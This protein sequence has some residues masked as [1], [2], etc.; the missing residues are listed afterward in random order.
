[1][2]FRPGPRL[3]DAAAL[4]A[5]LLVVVISFRDPIFRGLVAFERDTEV[6]FYPLSAWFSE[7]FK[8]GRFP[9]WTPHVFAGYP[10]LADGENG[11]ANPLNLLFLKFLSAGH[12]LLWQRVSS[13]A[14]A[15]LGM[16]ALCRALGVGSLAA[17]LGAT[18]FSL[19]SFFPSQQHHENVTRT[20]A[21]LPMVLA[22]VEWSFHHKGWRRHAFLTAG[23]L[24]LGM[25]TVGLHPQI[26]AMSLLGFSSFVTYR[27]LTL[28]APG[29]SWGPLGLLWR[30]ALVAWVGLYAGLL[31][32]ALGALQLVPLAEL[33]TSTYRGSQPDYF[34]ATSYALP[35]PNLIDLVFP[36]FFRLPDADYWSLWAKW[37]TELYLGIA[38]L[39]LA[40]VG[41]ALARRRTTIYF[42]LLALVA[43]WLAFASYAPFDLYRMLWD[44]P[45]FSAFRVPG[46]YTYLFVLACSVLAAFGLQALADMRFRERWWN[47]YL[48]AVVL[49]ALATA[50]GVLLIGMQNLRASL[51]A[52]PRGATDWINS[53]YLSLRHHL[54]GLAAAQ[55][56]EGLMKS[57]D[58]TNGRTAF[59]VMLIG[60][61]F[62]L[63]IA[64]AVGRRSPAVW[65]FGIVGL[66]VMDLLAFGSSL[67]GSV[68]VERL[69]APT[70]AIRFLAQC[71]QEP[72]CRARA[73]G[74]GGISEP[75]WRV[76]TPGT[77]DSLE[78]DQLVPFRIPDIGGYASPD[79]RRNFAYW[80]DLSS[81]QNQ[82]ADIANVRYLVAHARP[83]ALP[84]YRNVA[85]DPENPLMQGSM[86]ALGGFESYNFDGNRGHRLQI[87]AS[88]TRSLDVEADTVVAEATIVP[89]EGSPQVIQLRAGRDLAEAAYD[90][91][92]VRGR[93]KHPK[94]EEVAFQR[95]DRFVLDG[96]VYQRLAF[97]S[98]RD[99]ASP[100]DVDR[101]EV[102]YVNPV[103]GIE[104]YGIGIYNF[105]TRETT[106]AYR[107]M[108]TKLR[109][110]YR[111][112]EVRIFENSA[113]YPRAY[114]VASG[115]VFGG[116]ADLLPAMQER[117]FDSTVEVMVRDPSVPPGTVRR[118]RTASAQPPTERPS[119]IPKASEPLDIGPNHAMFQVSAPEGGYF[120]HVAN[121]LP[122]WRAWVDGVEAPILLANGLFRAVP[123]SRGDHIVL[124]RYEPF[125][126]DLGLRIT[127]V[128]GL[129]ALMSLIG[130]FIGIVRTRA[131]RSA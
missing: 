84:S 96:S 12:A 24:A 52:D 74:P 91:P 75:Q 105:D 123:V 115:I 63:I 18:C 16:Y 49:V 65:R 37:E 126:V 43:L 129:A 88:L 45:G 118:Q 10:L 82:L 44:L 131:P 106:A 93:V 83:K 98:E 107:E 110:V 95:P 122:G 71:G 127:A 4:V 5:I 68:P 113:A 56:Y 40:V 77:I 76:F 61:A 22:C 50:A 108:R 29:L 100:M 23:G 54:E 87:I 99:L 101:I 51:V 117:P 116:N 80:T 32:L 57:L 86:N 3:R 9:L 114:V 1:M 102:R 67:H 33:A 111:D 13:V 19:G 69:G 130:A 28:S 21:W 35:I 89:R 72:V 15:A 85:Y 94:P 104:V 48:A 125:S 59:G 79:L 34:F 30:V 39:I 41:V 103:G 60:A 81:L 124:L 64:A 47:R 20:A 66:T 119:G 92:D 11:L 58:P 27:G 46:R 53:S 2:T 31:G 90:R 62:T 38:P 17:L 6:F 42:T 97:Y 14:I 70:A 128:A 7:E 109:M 8:A 78:F 112:D 73:E 36:Y 120:V 121:F 25:A 55:V 26:L